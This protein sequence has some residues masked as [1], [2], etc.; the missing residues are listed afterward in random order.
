MYSL[1]Q[2]RRVVGTPQ[3]FGRELNRFY[4]SH[5]KTRSYNHAGIDIF[6]RDWDMLVIL[7]ACRY[8]TFCTHSDLPGTLRSVISRGSSTPEFLQ[9][10]LQGRRLAD[11]VYV[12]ANPQLDRQNIDVEFHDVIRVWEEDGWDEDWGTVLPETMAEYT[13]QAYETYPNKRLLVHFIQPH[14]PF[15]TTET[16]FDKQH[17]HNSA[18]QTKNMW[19][20]LMEGDLDI[21]GERIRELY[22]DNL[23][24]TLPH[25]RE[26][27]Q[28]IPGK[29][30]VSSDHGNLFG[31]RIGPVPIREWGHPGAIHVENLVR[32]PWLTYTNE[33]RR[34]IIEESTVELELRNEELAEERLKNLGYR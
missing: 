27:L 21:P 33:R 19:Q 34:K 6:N 16:E 23:V 4:Y 11:T 29:S 2:L 22:E 8:D 9:G 30:V 24:E 1:W 18:E 5:F 13:Q 25:V 17:L 7:D 15:L 28:T 12:T 31:K 3:L 14:Y 32:V 26:L 10:N 20:M